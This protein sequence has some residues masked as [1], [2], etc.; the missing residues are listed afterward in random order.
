VTDHIER[1]T[2]IPA[3]PIDRHALNYPEQFRNTGS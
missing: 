2:G 1:L 3:S